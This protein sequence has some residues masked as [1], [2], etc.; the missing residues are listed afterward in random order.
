MST[1]SLVI[2][3]LALTALDSTATN[4]NNFYTVGKY[5]ND[6]INYYN[7]I[8]YFQSGALVFKSSLGTKS[9]TW[10]YLNF[11]SDHLIAYGIGDGDNSF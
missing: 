6:Y 2:P 8:S 11:F 5:T 9:I 3:V 10:A 7:F 4:A 1:G